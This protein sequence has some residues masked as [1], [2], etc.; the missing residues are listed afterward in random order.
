MFTDTITKITNPEALVKARPP[1]TRG[2]Q[3]SR[4]E[5]PPA[6]ANTLG[7]SPVRVAGV[8]PEG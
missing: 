5:G 6:H 1:L 3:G 7:S 2:Q 4:Q 8:L